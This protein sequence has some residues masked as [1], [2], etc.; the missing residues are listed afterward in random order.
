MLPELLNK[1]EDVQ[2][3]SGVGMKHVAGQLQESL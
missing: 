2:Q 1:N 3:L